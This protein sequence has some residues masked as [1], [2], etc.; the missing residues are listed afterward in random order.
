MNENLLM[1]QFEFA[2]MIIL[3]VGNEV[4]EEIADI[5]PKGFPNSLRWQLGHV[6]VTVE[7]ILFYFAN[8]KMNLP[9]DYSELF[10]RG[11][12]PSS[13]SSEPPAIEE[14]FTLL[15]EQQSRV[16]ETFS[17]RMD[18]KLSQTFEAGPL[19]LETIGEVL[20]FAL[21]HESEHIG[22]IKSLKNAVKA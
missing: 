20:L 12:K 1:N 7:E 16:K 9:A 21:F 10:S 4:T 3:N 2:R 13:W 6:Y 11:T 17:N 14:L 8:E 15:K 18:E 19:K 5:I 22:C